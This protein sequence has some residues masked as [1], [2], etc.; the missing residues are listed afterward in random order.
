[1]KPAASWELGEGRREG[2]FCLLLVKDTPGRK[3]GWNH[4]ESELK[5]TLGIYLM[6]IKI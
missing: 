2:A 5:G 1:M 4:C 3:Q 6:S